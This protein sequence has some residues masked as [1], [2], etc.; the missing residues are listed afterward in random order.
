MVVV[1]IHIS[2][3][4]GEASE[5]FADEMEVFFAL[6]DRIWIVQCVGIVDQ[7]ARHNGQI[8]RVRG[9]LMRGFR[10]EI[11]H[12]AI[13]IGEMVTEMEVGDVCDFHEVG[14]LK[15]KQTT[16]N[17]D[18]VVDENKRRKTRIKYSVRLC[19]IN[20]PF[21]QE[22]QL[23]GDRIYADQTLKDT[24]LKEQNLAFYT[25]VKRKKGQDRLT[26]DEKRFSQK[27]SRIR[28]HI[29]GLFRWIERKTNL[30][31]ASQVRS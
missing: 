22:G 4:T 1:A 19:C 18:R 28:Q 20:L 26:A 11:G 30:S 10:N 7:I 23:Y 27:V 25:P 6:R 14:V 24:L 12:L 13:A 29:E 8:G 15:K 16:K 9:E 3:G 21:L 2:D 5:A 31:V 17:A